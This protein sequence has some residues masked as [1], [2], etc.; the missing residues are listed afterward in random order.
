[1]TIFAKNGVLT[2]AVV[3]IVLL[4]KLTDSPVAL[5]SIPPPLPALLNPPRIKFHWVSPSNSIT[6]A[7]TNTTQQVTTGAAD[8]IMFLV[9]L[10]W[11]WFSLPLL[12]IVRTWYNSELIV[13]EAWRMHRG[14][15][16]IRAI[17]AQKSPL[18]KKAEK[19]NDS[20]LVADCCC[21][22]LLFEFDDDEVCCFRFHNHI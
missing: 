3:T 2:I 5:P 15:M 10:L 7:E 22:W 14:M 8:I 18:P 16:R 19:I 4:N 9:L 1:M 13:Y 17:A 12:P 21:F 20:S 11:S 6:R